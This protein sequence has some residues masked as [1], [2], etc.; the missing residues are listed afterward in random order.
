LP[1]TWRLW[2]KPPTS[3]KDG[4]WCQRRFNIPVNSTV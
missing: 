2:I 1:M 4:S 3:A